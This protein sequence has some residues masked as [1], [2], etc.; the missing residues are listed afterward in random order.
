MKTNVAQTSID[1]FHDQAT[2]AAI[3]S[4]RER[5][6]RRVIAETKAGKPSCMGS[7][8]E[9][10]CKVGDVELYQKSSVSRACHDIEEDGSIVIDGRE[11]AY[12]ATEPKKHGRCIVKHF[13]LVLL[14]PEITATQGELF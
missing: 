6:A 10:F 12:K 3:A 2:Q 1:A 7:L 5:V 13:C 4:Q 14:K 11:Y 9:Y 8:W